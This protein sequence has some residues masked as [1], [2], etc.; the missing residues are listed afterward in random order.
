MPKRYT[1]PETPEQAAEE[2]YREL[3]S[4]HMVHKCAVAPNAC[5]KTESSACKRGCDTNVFQSETTFD[6]LGY[7]VYPRSEE[8]D[9]MVVPHNR[10]LL[11][12]WNGHANVESAANAKSV[13]YL[14]DYLY[15]GQRKVRVTISNNDTNQAAVS[16]DTDE[17]EKDEVKLYLNARFLC[18]MDAVWRILGYHTYPGPTSSVLTIKIKMQ[19]QIDDL[20]LDGK[21]SDMQ[22][23][24]N[25]P[26][27]LK[28]KKYTEM[29]Q[30]YITGKNIL[31][32]LCF[33]IYI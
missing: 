9:L 22:A 4:K 32:Q 2:E 14:Y 33:E 5:K 18:A 21:S 23:Y 13:M 27:F 10:R 24:L 7:P 15:K 28:D 29:F 25:R 20:E 3:V 12:D 30:E 26:E 6:S 31:R 11:L 19:H 8:A 16:D 17:I 1:N